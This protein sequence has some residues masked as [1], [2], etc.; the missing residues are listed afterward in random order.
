MEDNEYQEDLILELKSRFTELD[1]E[2][3]DWEDTWIK[4]SESIMP[5]NGVFIRSLRRSSIDSNGV[6]SEDNSRKVPFFNSTNN[7]TAY[8]AVRKAASGFHAKGTSP[9]RKW[10]ELSSKNL[11]ALDEDSKKWLKSQSNKML[12]YFSRNNVYGTIFEVY[13][14]L[15]VFGS[16]C[17][18][19]HDQDKKGIFLEHVDVGQ[20]Y[21][22][23]DHFNNV[24]T[25]CRKVKF[26]IR[27]LEQRFGYDAL[28]ESSKEKF[29]N[30]KFNDTVDVFQWIM[31]RRDYEPD[32]DNV[33]L[34]KYAEYWY[35]D[36]N[37]EYLLFET[38]YDY[39]PVL[40]PRFGVRPGCVYGYSPGM[41]TLGDILT[42]EH[43]IEKRGHVLDLLVSP[44]ISVPNEMG[45]QGL[46][47]EPG[48]VFVSP[49]TGNGV[50]VLQAGGN[51]IQA[52]QMFVDE[53]RK[54]IQSGFFADVFMMIQLADKDN[55]KA[56][57]VIERREEKMAMIGPAIE[58]I[59]SDFIKPLVEKTF[60][61]MMSSGLFDEPPESFTNK[62]DKLG[63]DVEFLS[64]LLAAQR[65]NDIQA[66]NGFIQ[67]VAALGSEQAIDR[68]DIDNTITAL[69]DLHNPPREVLRSKEDADKLREQRQQMIQAQQQMAMAEQ[70]A[71]VV[72]SLNKSRG[73][74]ASGGF[75]SLAAAQQQ[76]E[77]I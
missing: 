1:Q 54:E 14:D 2:R 4:L 39:F 41:Y 75:D 16:A 44:P 76:M 38:G 51:G 19:L 46:R 15:L 58:Y 52:I 3:L 31:P 36:S 29:D 33:K 42:L 62:A 8:D 60:H 74:G 20:F 28:C 43:A 18:I 72:E 48:A 64:P 71:K 53:T 70:G 25:F 27:Q 21:W 5:T 11:D 66:I 40:T 6:R 45:N 65:A 68:I 23:I 56:A 22:D 10:F 69:A 63:F 77:Q 55:M 9:S 49:M 50:N 17:L 34:K 59:V 67:N 61:I 37:N 24:D 13:I 32:K 73:A 7:K 57:E 35:E 30:K 12:G 26:T 47:F